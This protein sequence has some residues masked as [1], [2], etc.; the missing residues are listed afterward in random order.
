M[1][2]VLDTAQSYPSFEPLSDADFARDM[3]ERVVPFVNRL[4]K[5]H[6]LK[7]ENGKDIYCETLVPDV[8][9]VRG[10]IVLFHGFC[11]FCSKFDE[12]TY[13]ILHQGYAVC[14]FDEFGHG[15]SGREIDDSSKVHIERFQTYVDCAYEVVV[16]IAEPLAAEL[17]KMQGDGKE[18]DGGKAL[19]LLLFSHS[20]G[21]AVAALFLEQ[22]PSVFKAA[23]LASPMLEFFPKKRS[24]NTAHLF[25][26][27]LRTFGKGKTYFPGQKKFDGTYSF[28]AEKALTCSKNRFLYHFNKR[29]AQTR[30]QTWGGTVAWLDE[31]VKA[32]NRIFKKNELKKI[33]VPILV[34]QAEKD[35]TVSNGGQNRFVE[36]VPS[37][38][39]AVCPGANHELYNGTDETLSRWYPELFKFYDEFSN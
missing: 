1:T 34:F 8:K 3:D 25:V 18:R 14:R 24:Q 26:K 23:V 33:A 29:H 36:A 4:R 11:E 6:R 20:M 17:G 39:L 28:S 15:F 31:S 30:Y 5:D 35:A 19:P 12:F 22:H 7:T 32:I 21:G 37:A 38:R 9:K 16:K 2:T 10:L 13:Y 27:I